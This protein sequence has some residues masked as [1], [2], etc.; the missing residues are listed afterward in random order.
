MLRKISI[1]LILSLMI[2]AGVK[3]QAPENREEPAGG[4]CFN[5]FPPPPAT[6]YL[7]Q[8]DMD[9]SPMT[10]PGPNGHF[11]RAR[12]NYMGAMDQQRKHLE[13][14]RMLK[15]LELLDLSEDKEIQFLTAFK[16]MRK[17]LDEIRDQRGQLIEDLATALKE[18]K[19]DQAMVDRT[20]KDL[21]N[22]DRE[23][24]KIM[25]HFLQEARGILNPE[26]MGKFLVFQERFEFEIL[27]QLKDFHGRKQGGKP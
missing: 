14:F 6:C 21:I 22:L 26:Q 12:R 13:Q 16:G 15:L 17:D 24:T 27:E 25:E 5:G 19:V 10:G 23:K 2:T 18:D 7:A 8:A 9:D 11:G 4:C 3:A 1:L 20:S